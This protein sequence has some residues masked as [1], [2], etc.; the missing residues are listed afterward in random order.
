MVHIYA[1]GLLFFQICLHGY[2]RCWES[3]WKEDVPVVY[4]LFYPLPLQQRVLFV[5]SHF[6]YSVRSF[7]PGGGLMQVCVSRAS[8]LFFLGVMVYL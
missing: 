5:S 3:G 4:I 8:F 2:P 7:S 6:C 1:K